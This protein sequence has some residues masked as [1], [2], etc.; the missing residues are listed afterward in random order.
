MFVL[1]KQHTYVRTSNRRCMHCLVIRIYSQCKFLT[2]EMQLH[3]CHLCIH[4]P[5]S[6]TTSSH[7]CRCHESTTAREKNKFKMLPSMCI[8]SRYILFSR[9][10]SRNIR[11]IPLH[12]TSHLHARQNKHTLNKMKTNNAYINLLLFY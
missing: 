7:R 4:V 3:I 5:K 1:L 8:L 6:P 9:L 12:A 2:C 10:P 11:T